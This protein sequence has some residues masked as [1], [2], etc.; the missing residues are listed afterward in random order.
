MNRCKT[1]KHWTGELHDQG[2]C[3]VKMGDKVEVELKTGWDGGYVRYILT[4]EDFGCTE[5]EPRE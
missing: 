3:S 1:C 2:R 4:D 5:H